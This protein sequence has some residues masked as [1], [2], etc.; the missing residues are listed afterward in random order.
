[1]L[2][3]TVEQVPS[4]PGML[5][6]WQSPQSVAQQ[7]PS[8]H[9][10]LSHSPVSGQ[11]SPSATA[12]APLDEPL[13]ALLEELLSPPELPELASGQLA[14]KVQSSLRLE[15]PLSATTKMPTADITP[16]RAA[17]GEKARIELAAYQSA[18]AAATSDLGAWRLL[19]R[20]LHPLL[21][22]K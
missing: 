11:G 5:H 1:M 21:N 4:L 13:E 2:P 19:K 17:L 12:G 8:T 16:R 20:R 15:Q 14:F 22:C 6:A 18:P 9:L 10:L 7:T 3:G